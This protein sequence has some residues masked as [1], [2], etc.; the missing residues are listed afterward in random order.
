MNAAQSLQRWADSH[1]PLWLDFF[2]MALGVYIFLKGVFFIL[3]PDFISE[4]VQQT[5]IGY[6]WIMA[7]SHYVAPVHL[8]GGLM[9]AFGLLTRPACAFQIP[10]L[11]VAVLFVNTPGDGT[12]EWVISLITLIALCV[13]FFY[14]SG[15]LS[16]D[17]A[18]ETQTPN[19][20]ANY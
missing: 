17:H 19:T 11:L 7:I 4:L 5:G 16:L 9:I 15:K 6:L 1:H 14:G 8:F 18:M 20:D 3:N 2:R 10:I 13:F 12:N